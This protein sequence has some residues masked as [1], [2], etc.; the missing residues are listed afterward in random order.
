M[1]YPNMVTGIFI[2]RPNRFIAHVM[3][4]GREE[5]AHVKNTGRCKELLIPGAIVYLQE[6]DNPNRKTRFSLIAVQKGELLVNIDSQA[7][8]KVMMEA[9]TKGLSLPEL[10]S[11]ISQIKPESVYGSSRFDFYITAGNQKAYLEIKG[12]TLE[13]E[14][15][16]KFPDAPT[17]RGVKHI[18]ELMEAVKE[19][20]LA[21]AVFIVQM[22]GVSHVTPNDETHSEFG[23]ALRQA[24]N[25]GLKII[26]YDCLVAP[27]LLELNEAIPVIL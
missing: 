27:N 7:P 20:F 15:V 6:H 1:K 2:K 8:N 4:N 17:Q 10:N 18:L 9:L 22:K 13:D 11:P 12:V 5:I 19:G 14:G 26:A 3:I 16:A 24:H 23:Q 25:E 21:Y